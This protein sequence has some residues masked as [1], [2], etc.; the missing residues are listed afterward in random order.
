MNGSE[1]LVSH[2]KIIANIRA[3]ANSRA[4]PID[5]VIPIP[6][7]ADQVRLN[8]ELR[9]LKEQIRISPELDKLMVASYQCDVRL[10]LTFDS[11]K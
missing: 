8:I 10:F 7:S 1:L 2:P 4:E 9:K 11:T 3:W 6:I 5:D